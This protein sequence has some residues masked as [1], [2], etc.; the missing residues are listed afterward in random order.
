MS[1][2]RGVF[3]LFLATS[4]GIINGI[5]AFGPA[6]KEQQLEKQRVEFETIN[7]PNEEEIAKLRIAEAEASRSSEPESAPKS[8]LRSS[9]WSNMSLWSK[10][11]S[12]V[13]NGT[14]QQSL[15]NTLSTEAGVKP[16]S[17][18]QISRDR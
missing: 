2:V 16:N 12:A 7:H 4:F 9:W 11:N 13:K 15:S 6:L 18:E 10:D 1:R 5:W 3:P 17:L 8:E 14:S